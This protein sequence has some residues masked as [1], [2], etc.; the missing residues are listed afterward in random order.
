V[1]RFAMFVGGSGMLFSLFVLSRSVVMTRLMMMM[2]GGGVMSSRL[3]VVL[4]CWMLG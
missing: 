2:S 4:G 1:R 3:M